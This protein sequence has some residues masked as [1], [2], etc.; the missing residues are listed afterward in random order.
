VIVEAGRDHSGYVVAF[1]ECAK[2]EAVSRLGIELH[3]D[4]AAPPV[5][6]DAFARTF[7]AE[8]QQEAMQGCTDA[9]EGRAKRYDH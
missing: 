8:I 9:F 3:L 5:I 2:P 4:D 6:A 1:T 7:P